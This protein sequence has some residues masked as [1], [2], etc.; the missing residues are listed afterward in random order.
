MRTKIESYVAFNGLRVRIDKF[1]ELWSNYAGHCAKI[2]PFKRDL[3]YWNDSPWSMQPL[4]TIACYDYGILDGYSCVA[5]FEIWE[6][7]DGMGMEVYK[8]DTLE[9]YERYSPCQDSPN[10]IKK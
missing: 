9:E 4:K 1:I 3:R 7:K 6:R 2:L 8:F 5:V 10:A